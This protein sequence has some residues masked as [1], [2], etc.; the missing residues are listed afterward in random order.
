MGQNYQSFGIS[1]LE[2]K[3]VNRSVMSDSLRP[4][5]LY[6]DP[7]TILR[8]PL[9]N[10]P[11]QNT[12]VGTLSLLQGIVPTQGSNPGLLHCRQILYQRSHKGSPTRDLKDHLVQPSHLS[13]WEKW[14]SDLKHTVTKLQLESSLQVSKLSTAPPHPTTVCNLF[15]VNNL[16]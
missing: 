7:W 4:Y 13:G 3:K 15:S 14:A 6:I 5:G 10:S 2:R 16:I 11:G 12:G 1:D 8:I 9:R